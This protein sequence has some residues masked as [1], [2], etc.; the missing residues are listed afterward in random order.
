MGNHE[1]NALAFHTKDPE[2]PGAHVRFRSNKNIRQHSKTISALTDEEPLGFGRVCVHVGKRFSYDAWVKGLDEGRSFVTTG[3]MLLADLDGR[4]PGE[5]FRPS[6][7]GPHRFRLSG[8][9][10]SAAPLS[11]IEVVVNGEVAAR[12]KPANRKTAAGAYESV[13]DARSQRRTEPLDCSAANRLLPSGAYARAWLS[14]WPRSTSISS[15]VSEST[16]R[17]VPSAQ[18]RA[19]CRPSGL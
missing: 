12:I 16:I 7:D 14:R 8:R 6:G 19:S 11:R 3:P 9:A 5:V 2:R 4:E 10:L 13:L 17:T 18:A 1:L 15:P